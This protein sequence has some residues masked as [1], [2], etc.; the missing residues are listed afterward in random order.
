MDVPQ[1]IKNRT[2]LQSSN[3]TTGYLP[4][5]YKNTN[6]KG[7][8][9]PYMY[10]SIIPNSQIMEAAEVSI[11]RW[12]HNNVVCICNEIFSHKNEWNLAIYNNMDGIKE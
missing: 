7:Y 11:D 8:M 9:H 5:K 3:C 10:S 2:T 6:L 4:H 1:N 12:M